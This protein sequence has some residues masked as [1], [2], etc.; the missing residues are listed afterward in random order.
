MTDT[1][2]RTVFVDYPA[3]PTSAPSVPPTRTKRRGAAFAGI[4]S[5]LALT[6]VGVAV[7][8]TGNEETAAPTEQISPVIATVIDCANGGLTRDTTTG[9]I[10]PRRTAVIRFENTGSEPA[11]FTFSVDGVTPVMA[12]GSPQTPRTLEPGAASTTTYTV[13]VESGMTQA[14]C[15][16]VSVRTRLA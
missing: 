2:K 13:P 16:A 5:L 10:S 7:T 1:E 15:L 8:V 11:S 12:N 9:A 4:G 3:Q 6:A 14:S